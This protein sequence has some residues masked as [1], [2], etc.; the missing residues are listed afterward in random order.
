MGNYLCNNR[1]CNTVIGTDD[2]PPI[3]GGLCRFHSL[4][5][6]GS[7]DYVMRRDASIWIEPQKGNVCVNIW[8]NPETNLL[9]INVLPNDDSVVEADP[10]DSMSIDVG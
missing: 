10:I 6:L 8:F 4:K 2:D 9:S 5:P 1:R 3:A 7:G